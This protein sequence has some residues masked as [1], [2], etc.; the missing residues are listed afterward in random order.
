[1]GTARST[2]PSPQRDISL[3]GLG[4]P[5]FGRVGYCYGDGFCHFVGS[6]IQNDILRRKF[7]LLQR[8]A[9]MNFTSSRGCQ[10]SSHTPMVHPGGI[11]VS[12]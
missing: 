10:G 8:R 2:G 11:D 1:M 7:K 4:E 9:C 12:Q 5:G 3:I 6:L